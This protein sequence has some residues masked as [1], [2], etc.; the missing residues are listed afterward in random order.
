M[1]QKGDRVVLI[2]D[3]TCGGLHPGYFGLRG[4]TGTIRENKF[5]PYGEREQIYVQFDD[6][7][8]NNRN[9]YAFVDELDFESKIIPYTEFQTGDTDEDI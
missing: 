1:F 4:M 3:S 6:K 9:W 2:T 8:Q 5:R 7:I